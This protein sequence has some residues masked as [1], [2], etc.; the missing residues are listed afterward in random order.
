MSKDC[1]HAAPFRY[2]Q[3]CTADP[4][5]IGLGRGQVRA[6]H[7]Q[8]VID[9]KGELDDKLTALNVFFLSSIFAGVDP[10]EQFRLRL[11]AEYMAGYS[12]ILA[13]RIAAF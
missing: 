12:R 7:Q 11:Q 3:K 1:P 4:C 2:C 6:P 8:R 13:Q 9:E 10:A 5:P